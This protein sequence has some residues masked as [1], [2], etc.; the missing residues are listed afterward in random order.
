MG[1]LLGG[2][3]TAESELGE[4]S[5]FTLYLP[6]ELPGSVT[7]RADLTDTPDG[8][9]PALNGDGHADATEALQF[10]RL[11]PTTPPAGGQHLL[12]LE[13][14]RGGLLTL[15]AYSAVS[16]LSSPHPSTWSRRPAP[17]RALKP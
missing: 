8:P 14:V 4:G 12:V 2:E 13:A 3:I 10:S 1:A 16:D 6:C 7:G 15:L 17:S 9:D 11:C 5:T